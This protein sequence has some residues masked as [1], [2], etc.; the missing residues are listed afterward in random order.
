MPSHGF[1]IADRLA[2][3]T[4]LVA[5]ET[6]RQRADVELPAEVP[7]G[8]LLPL[9]L[10]A[11]TLVTPAPAQP[12]NVWLLRAPNGVPLHPARSLID[13]GIVDGMRLVLQDVATFQMERQRAV[14]TTPPPPPQ[15]PANPSTGGIGIRW[16][17][18]G[19]LP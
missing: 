19:L 3:R 11:F 1:V 6:P 18:D 17:R 8:E 4:V 13:G 10:D 14:A 7:V 2:M 5:L 15:I 12:A 9:L 16:N